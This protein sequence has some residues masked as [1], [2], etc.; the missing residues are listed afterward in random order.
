M[1]GLGSSHNSILRIFLLL[2][3]RILSL[4]YLKVMFSRVIT[5]NCQWGPIG[6]RGSF[7]VN[8]LAL[9]IT[10]S[11][12]VAWLLYIENSSRVML[13]FISS[14]RLAGNFCPC[15]VAMGLSLQGMLKDGSGSG[16][17]LEET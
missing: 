11:E 10:F 2:V 8:I 14:A 9:G 5:H 17:C 16:Q 1:C 12:T 3:E 4:G 6:H 7:G 15:L 13:N